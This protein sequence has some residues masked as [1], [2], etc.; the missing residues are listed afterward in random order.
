V[1]YLG[2]CAAPCAIET[3]MMDAIPAEPGSDSDTD[4]VDRITTAFGTLAASPVLP[5]MHRHEPSPISEHL[6]EPPEGQ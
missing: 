1:F 2:A 5:L 4:P 3:H 6:P